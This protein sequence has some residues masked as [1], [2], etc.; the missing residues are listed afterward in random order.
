MQV[1]Q[2]YA[3]V[4]PHE[5]GDDAVVYLRDAQATVQERQEQL[6]TALADAIADSLGGALA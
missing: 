4:L 2:G 6:R 1:L 5:V 3:H